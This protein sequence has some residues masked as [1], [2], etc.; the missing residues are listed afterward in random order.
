MMKPPS[1]FECISASKIVVVRRLDAM[2]SVKFIA[3]CHFHNP[4]GKRS[5]RIIIFLPRPEAWNAHMPHT[6]PNTNEWGEN[7]QC[8]VMQWKMLHGAKALMQMNWNKHS[9]PDSYQ[10]TTNF[11]TKYICSKCKF[12]KKGNNT[13][14]FRKSSGDE[15]ERMQH[16]IGA[17]AKQHVPLVKNWME[18]FQKENA[19]K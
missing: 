12:I 8:L 3:F 10:K 16:E 17:G 4:V 6:H 1:I 11:H 13:Q 5:I 2:N 9:P 14:T 18:N 19:T 7:F 15:V